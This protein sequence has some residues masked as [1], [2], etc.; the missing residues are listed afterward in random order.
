M[1]AFRNVPSARRPGHTEQ[2]EK[3]ERK[4]VFEEKR[5]LA[6]NRCMWVTHRVSRTEGWA[7]T[8]IPAMFTM[9]PFNAE[10]F[11]SSGFNALYAF[12]LRNIIVALIF[13]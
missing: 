5:W 2:K 3:E 10:I 13:F 12:E 11:S 9:R 8:F 6:A 4:E 1:H 7:G